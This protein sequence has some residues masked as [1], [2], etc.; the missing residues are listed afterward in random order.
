M[1]NPYQRRLSTGLL[2]D[3]PAATAPNRGERCQCG[4]RFGWETAK[5]RLAK[6]E[7]R[8]CTVFA[9]FGSPAKAFILP[10]RLR[11]HIRGVLEVFS[12]AGARQR[13]GNGTP[14]KYR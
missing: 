6:G 1:R 8:R 13:R 3:G 7:Y 12:V 14:A 5:E 4:M 2:E 10:I 9:H 11:K